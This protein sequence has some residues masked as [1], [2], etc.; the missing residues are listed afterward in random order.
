M[1]AKFEQH[2]V[3]KKDAVVVGHLATYHARYHFIMDICDF[4]YVQEFFQNLDLSINTIKA[5]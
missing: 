4:I 3:V 1:G 5:S 2:A